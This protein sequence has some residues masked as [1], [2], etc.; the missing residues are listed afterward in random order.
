MTIS[1]FIILGLNIYFSEQRNVSFFK[2]LGILKHILFFISIYICMKF[3]K[4]FKNYFFSI[5]IFLLLFVS[6]DT[7][8]Q[9]Y[10]SRDIFGFEPYV[11]LNSEGLVKLRRLSGP[12]GDEYIVGAFISKITFLALIF[13][14]L[15]NLNKYNE[16]LIL[17]FLIIVLLSNERSAFLMLLIGSTIYIFLNTETKIFKK[18]SKLIA[19]FIILIFVVFQNNHLIRHYQKFDLTK[20]EENVSIF[21]N[22][23]DTQ[24]GAHY[25]TALEISKQNL[26]LG[27]G[28]G[29]F[30]YIC[31]DKTYE[32]IKSKFSEV[33][34]STH[35]HNIYL[36]ILSEAGILIFLLFLYLNALIF[37]Y[38]LKKI[39]TEKR[40]N[41]ILIF[42][43]Y[44]IL[45]NPIQ[46]TGSFFST[47]NGIFYW[48]LIGL[49]VYQFDFF[50][51]AK[52]NG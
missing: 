19:I 11:V 40:L 12:F 7:L 10:F 39:I 36:E 34:C 31:G 42:C 22:F 18:I 45:F 3:C 44:V 8:I 1:F 52:K 49:I 6:F 16:L 4:N 24:W 30:R 20:K 35:P 47:W 41:N 26:I 15:K 33:R 14:N 28:L 32:N 27:S 23:Q 29:T 51:I 25:L 46:T 43:A 48:L 9:F 2:F 17:F 13:F 5:L 50:K 38:L 37:F 21:K